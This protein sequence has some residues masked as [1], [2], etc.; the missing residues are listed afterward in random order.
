MQA[1]RQ[2]EPAVIVLESDDEGQVSEHLRTEGCVCRRV[3]V[4]L[5]R[6]PWHVESSEVRPERTGQHSSI[7][8]KVSR[9]G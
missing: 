4:S 1:A 6:A 5:A 2:Q 7:D 9:Q 3:L 8:L